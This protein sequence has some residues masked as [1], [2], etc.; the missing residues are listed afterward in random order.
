MCVS[1][2]L[3]VE[4]FHHFAAGRLAC[5][6]TFTCRCGSIRSSST[7]HA[8]PPFCHTHTVGGFAVSV[9]L[10]ACERPCYLQLWLSELTY[11]CYFKWVHWHLGTDRFAEV[12]DIVSQLQQKSSRFCSGI[13]HYTRQSAFRDRRFSPLKAEELPQLSISLSVLHDFEPCTY[14]SVRYSSKCCPTQVCFLC[15][16]YLERM[17]HQHSWNSN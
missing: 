14:A 17:G 13:P 7:R 4:E 16:R 8:V 5:P 12:I 2:E 11:L 15:R 3:I 1:L 10:A 9:A 6:S